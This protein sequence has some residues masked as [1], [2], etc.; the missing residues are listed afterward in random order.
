[1]L[2]S[3]K[4]L[5]YT[6]IIL[7]ESILWIGMWL[8]DEYLASLLTVILVPIFFFI[9][10]ISLIAEV[11][12]RSRVPRSWFYI[13]LISVVIPLIIAILVYTLYE[14]AFD[15]LQDTY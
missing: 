2:T 6:E 15:W 12:E 11:V 5:G 4:K 3:L 9:L 13:M 7:I 8:L 1:M 10:V 14:G